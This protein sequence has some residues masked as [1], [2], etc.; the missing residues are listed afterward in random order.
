MLA[1]FLL[2][3]L[4]DVVSGLAQVVRRAEQATLLARQAKATPAEKPVALVTLPLLVNEDQFAEVW[5]TP[6]VREAR[7]RAEAYLAASGGAA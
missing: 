3:P 5:N 2:H 4:C 1:F 7:L 6:A